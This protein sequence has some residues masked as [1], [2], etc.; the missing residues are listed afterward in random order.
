MAVKGGGYRE[1]KEEK[2]EYVWMDLRE[3]KERKAEHK[4]K[5]FPKSGKQMVFIQAQKEQHN[6]RANGT[7]PME[8]RELVFTFL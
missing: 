8:R 3:R 6:S 7:S 2:L 4:L 5:L 1:D